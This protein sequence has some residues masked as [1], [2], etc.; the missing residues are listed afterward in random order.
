MKQ[1]YRFLLIVV[2]GIS[3]FSSINASILYVKPGAGSS[4]WQGQ[5]NVY[6]DLQAA[7]ADAISGDQIWVAGGTY[8]P[9]EGTDR[10]ISFELKDGVELYGG[11]AGN[12]TSLTERNWQ[13]NE[14]I[15]SGD[16]GEVAV[17]TDNSFNVLKVAGLE[18]NPSSYATILDGFIVEGGFADQSVGSNR[19]G[20]GLNLRYTSPIIRNFIFRDNYSSHEGGAVYG[21]KLPQANFGNV[22]FVNNRSGMKGGAIYSSGSMMQLHNCLFYNNKADNYGGAIYGNSVEV[23]NS[24]AWNNDAN[25]MSQFMVNVTA[26][27][28]IVQGGY[29]GSGNI[30]I[31]PVLMNP[32]NG[33]F[34]LSYYSPALQTGNSEIAPDWLSTDFFGSSRITDGTINMGPLEGF[35]VVPEMVSPNDRALFNSGTSEVLVSWKLPN[36]S[37]NHFVKYSIEYAK[38]GEAPIRIENIES[39][40]YLIQGLNNTDK[41]QWRVGGLTDSGQLKWSIWKAF[42]IKREHPLYVSVDGSGSGSSWQDAM[43]QI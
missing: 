27:H 4:V 34:R 9:T 14:T 29:R 15:L 18:L 42:R 38:N 33:D 8:K 40:Y 7:L 10:S 37:N 2:I 5:T 23:F 26:S 36:G 6:T 35:A 32:E 19:Q 41:I 11:F 20:S 24:I 43:S 17:N 22:I 3:L 28:C 30:N 12:E 31:D 25:E 13:V 21:Y 1:V 16:I 39:L